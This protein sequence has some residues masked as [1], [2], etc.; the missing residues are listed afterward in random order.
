MDLPG[1]HQHPLNRAEVEDK[2]LGLMR[3]VLPRPQAL[4]IV[5]M[6]PEIERL[7]DVSD[8]VRTLTPDFR[9]EVEPGTYSKP[10]WAPSRTP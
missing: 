5:A 6:C 3:R 9:R 8:L 4:D 2:A 10:T 7:S 1:R